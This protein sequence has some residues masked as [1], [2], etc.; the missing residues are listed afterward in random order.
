MGLFYDI[1]DMLVA[2]NWVGGDSNR[3]LYISLFLL[4]M[5]LRWFL[6]ACEI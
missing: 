6:C 4:R 5:D 1:V 3:H 2:D